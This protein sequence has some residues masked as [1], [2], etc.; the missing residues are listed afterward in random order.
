MSD[1]FDLN[2][3]DGNLSQPAPFA[4]CVFRTNLEPQ[5]PAMSASPI[6]LVDFASLMLSIAKTPAG[7]ASPTASSRVKLEPTDAPAAAP[8]AEAAAAPRSVP[9]PVLLSSLLSV[10]ARKR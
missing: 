2:T 5:A 10:G 9:P 1:Q 8:A 3:F 4:F 7:S 6:E